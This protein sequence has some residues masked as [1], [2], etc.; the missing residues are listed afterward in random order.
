MRRRAPIAAAASILLLAAGADAAV[1]YFATSTLDVSVI[2]P[3]VR[4]EAGNGA[5]SRFVSSFTL[6]TNATSFSAVLE[7]K[8][9]GEVRVKDVAVLVNDGASARTVTITGSQVANANVLE[10]TWTVKNGSDA[11]ATLDMRA[12][13]TSASFTLPAS[14][15]FSL[16]E[17]LKLVGGAGKNNATVSFTMGMSL[18]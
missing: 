7:A 17:R 11:I 10:F 12:A 8:A 3:P 14:G 6:T 9:G 4:F 18:S 15:A 13:P 5:S 1:G 16:D 2:A